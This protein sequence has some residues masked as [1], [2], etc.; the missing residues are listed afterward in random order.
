MSFRT[1][2]NATVQETPVLKEVQ[3][4][5]VQ[6]GYSSVTGSLFLLLEQEYMSESGGG[7]KLGEE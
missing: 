3:K 1:S 2:Q 4:P 6:R 5:Q 7:L